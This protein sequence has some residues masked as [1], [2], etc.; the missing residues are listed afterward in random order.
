MFTT[1]VRVLMQFLIIAASVFL[2]LS[3]ND[4]AETWMNMTALGFIATLGQD[5]LEVAKR[6]V[7]GHHVQGAITNLNYQLTLEHDYPSWFPA[8]R[9]MTLLMSV[10]GIVGFAVF[11]FIRPDSV[12]H[13][14]VH[15]H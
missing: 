15:H 7:F 14:H 5:I 4:P 3:S 10:V 11:I 1:V 13:E 12:C 2:F 8:V 6:G 9:N